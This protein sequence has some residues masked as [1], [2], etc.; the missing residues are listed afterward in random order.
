MI[1]DNLSCWNQ[2]DIYHM[3]E[4]ALSFH[5]GTMVALEGGY[6]GCLCYSVAQSD[7]YSE[8]MAVSLSA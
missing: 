1:H 7:I 5:K 3:K 6:G 4:I 2:L 8:C